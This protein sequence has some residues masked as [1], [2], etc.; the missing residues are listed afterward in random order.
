MFTTT[1]EFVLNLVWNLVTANMFVFLSSTTSFLNLLQVYLTYNTLYIFEAVE[2]LSLLFLFFVFYNTLST[3][4]NYYLQLF[5]PSVTNTSTATNSPKLA[6]L[7]TNFWY[8]Y[9]LN[10]LTTLQTTGAHLKK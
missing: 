2:P 4:L 3:I 8:L 7:P 5:I 6:L 10:T 1:L 9:K